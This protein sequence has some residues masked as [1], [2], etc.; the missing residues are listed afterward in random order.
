MVKDEMEVN[1]CVYSY[2]CYMRGL[3]PD[4]S[5]DSTWPLKSLCVEAG[6]WALG[7]N[8][9]HELITPKAT[10]MRMSK[11][12]DSCLFSR[13][14]WGRGKALTSSCIVE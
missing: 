2:Y 5:P 3:E 10:W 14:N 7:W 9:K 1:V 12:P 6:F 8:F 4:H 11:K 13:L